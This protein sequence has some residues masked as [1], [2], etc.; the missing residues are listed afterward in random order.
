MKRQ[1]RPIARSDLG[2]S[3]RSCYRIEDSV[4][5]KLRALGCSEHS[6]VAD[7]RLALVRIGQECPEWCEQA[8]WEA[9]AESFARWA[10]IFG[11]LRLFMALRRKRDE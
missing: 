11:D 6:S 10:G 2:R 7:I 3:I 9:I 5:G 1:E 8:A 4:W